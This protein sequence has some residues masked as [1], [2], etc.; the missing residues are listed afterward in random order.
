[1]VNAAYEP[2]VSLA[3]QGP[4]GL[5]RDIEVVVDTGFNGFLTLPTELVAELGLPFVSIGRA[6]LADGSEI[7]YDVHEAGVLWNGRPMLIEADADAA[8]PLLGMRL[9][10]GYSLYVEVAA[11]GP[12][13]IRAVE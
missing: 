5:S 4:S 9:L 7:V 1:M 13:V 6:T 8:T 2:V 12:V 11:G 10:D 3:V